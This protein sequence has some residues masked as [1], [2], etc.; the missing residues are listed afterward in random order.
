[1]R[2][3]LGFDGFLFQIASVQFDWVFVLVV[4]DQCFALLNNFF[5]F[6][7][8]FAFWQFFNGNILLEVSLLIDESNLAKETFAEF[9][10]NNQILNN[11]FKENVV[12]L[13]YL[14]FWIFHRVFGVGTKFLDIFRGHSRFNSTI[15]GYFLGVLFLF[16]CDSLQLI[17]TKS[18]NHKTWSQTTLKCRSLFLYH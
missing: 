1:M 16:I 7:T 2:I 9:L 13:S 18:F 11:K 4:T 10:K 5:N 12:T 14:C 8:I 6:G 17:V 15:L 3:K